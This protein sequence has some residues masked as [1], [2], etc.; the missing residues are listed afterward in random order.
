VVEGEKDVDNLWRIG[1]AATCNAHGASEPGK[2]PKWAA[3]H[4][5]QLRGADIVVLNDHDLAGCAHAETVC[6]LSRGL[7]K[8]V[9]RLDLKPHWPDIAKGGD[10]SDWL[11]AGHGPDDLRAL[12]DAAPDYAPA[13]KQ[14]N[15][16][17]P[18]DDE[19]ELARLARLSVV[20][21]ER[22]R[23]AAAEAFGCRAAMLDR[24]VSMKRAEL[25]LDR[26]DGKPG[27]ALDLPAPEPWPEL[28]DGAKLLDDMTSAIKRYVVI[29]STKLA[30]SR[31]G[32]FTP[33]SSTAF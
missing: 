30:A 33:I 29:P 31:C 23:K 14:G 1:F 11:A 16:G 8:R 12:I 13:G 18:P 6:R 3:A 5:E 19:A 25:G 21:Y 27:H 15:D 2:K 17:A 26:D 24:L 10:V 32:V 7:A 4:S 9:R 20:D 22:A 28:V